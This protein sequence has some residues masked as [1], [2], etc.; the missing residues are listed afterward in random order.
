MEV[1]NESSMREYSSLLRNPPVGP[2]AAMKPCRADL[3]SDD[4]MGVVALVR[5]NDRRDGIR[6][7]LRMMGG[8]EPLCRG[9]RGEIVIKPNCNTDDPFPRD[10]HP[11][12]VRTIAESLIEA[13]VPAE[14]IVV[15]DMSGRSRGLPTRHTMANLGIARVAEELGLQL[16]CFEEEQW[17]T[18]QPRGSRAWPDGIKIPRR[19]YE[20]DRVILAPI[21]RPHSTATFTISLKLAVGLID[22]VGREWLHNGEA[23]YEKMVELNLAYSADLVVADAMKILTDRDLTQEKAAEPG[24]IIAGSSRVAVDAVSVAVM[25]QYGV[26]GVSDSPVLGHDQLTMA[27]RLGL[28]SPRL[29]DI[30]LRTSNLAGDEGFG[31]MI[32]SIRMELS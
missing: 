30:A 8:L 3:Y 10:T 26:H 23:F 18:V 24:L 28:G 4:G 32:S 25:K 11:E 2:K 31:D 13:G 16:S 9:V 15:G 22:A 19:I 21:M 12:T 7:A 20:A 5:S 1:T 29:E 17:V 6:R 27:E 14:R